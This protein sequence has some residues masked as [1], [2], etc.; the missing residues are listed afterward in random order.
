MV[1]RFFKSY[2]PSVIITILILGVIFF[3]KPLIQFQNLF[4]FKTSPEMPLMAVFQNLVGENKLLLIIISIALLLVQAYYLVRLNLS[5]FFIEERTYLPA[6]LYLLFSSVIF[7]VSGFHSAIIGILFLLIVIDKL[8]NSSNATE[9][10]SGY[11]DMGFLLGL[12]SLF[13]S[14][15]LFYGLF[16]LIGLII[17]N[18]L[19][20]R[21]TIV[22]FIGI[23]TVFF[24][25]WFYYFFRDAQNEFFEIL[26]ANFLT[27]QNGFQLHYSIYIF[28]GYWGLLLILSSGNLLSRINQKKII[29]RKY[30]SVIILLFAFSLFCFFVVPGFTIATSF[31]TAISLSFLISDYFVHL[32]IKWYREVIFFLLITISLFVL[33]IY[34]F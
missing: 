11:Y 4:S 28:L 8:L 26:K 18:S 32:R 33:I 27:K 21:K 6:M 13:Y 5:Y 10:L 9:K 23:L 17:V 1:Y 12:G 7:T 19:N 22:F 2:Y 3:L 30:F 16:V 25:T 14:N 34:P 15:L 24:I 20:F 31:V 29:A